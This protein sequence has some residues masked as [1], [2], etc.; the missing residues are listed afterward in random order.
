MA[1]KKLNRAVSLDE[2]ERTEF[3]SFDWD[4]DWLDFFGNI[5]FAGTILT[6]G[7]S[8]NGKTS[9]AL[10]MCKYLANRGKRTAMNSMEQG[11]SASMK[12]QA[13]LVG[14]TSNSVPKGNFLLLDKEPIDELVI[15]LRKRR[16]PDFVVIDSLQYSGLNYKRYQ[17]I[18]DEF[19]GKKLIMFLSHADGKNPEG[20]VARRIRYDADTKIRIEGYR[21]FSMSRM[22]GGKPFTIWEKGARI[23]YNEDI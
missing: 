9:F 21:A 5:E 3:K 23:Y 16:S 2:L 13:K 10:Q 15:R 22:G 20:R 1:V 18:K 11:R 6:W 8:G 17:A 4:G 12:K 14:L 19:A 7:E